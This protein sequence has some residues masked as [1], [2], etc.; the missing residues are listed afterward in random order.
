[1]PISVCHAVPLLTL[2]GATVV[3]CQV[4]HQH[5]PPRSGEEY[6]GILESAERDEWQ[7]P[8]EV[9]TALSL[10]PGEVVADIGAGTGYFSRRFARHGAK[11]LAVDVDKT[12]LEAHWKG[13]EANVTKV[14]ATFDDPKLPAGGVNTVFFCDVVH[15]IDDRPAYFAKIR[16]ALKPEGRV[17]VIDFQKRE[18]PVGPR[19]EMKISREEMIKEWESAGFR[20]AGEQTFLPYQYFLE[21]QM[22]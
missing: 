18:L 2:L 15:H 3:F 12:L 14:L 5:H 7:L 1:M 21:F 4:H 19:V 20:L 13:G 6:A 8:H 10:K 9:V 11:V 17:V 16:K 22:K